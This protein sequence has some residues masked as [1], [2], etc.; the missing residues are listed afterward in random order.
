MPR[1]DSTRIRCAALVVLVTLGAAR[2]AGAEEPAVV[3]QPIA[4]AEPVERVQPAEAPP[5]GVFAPRRALIPV[6][7]DEAP[8]TR[9]WYGWQ[10][11]LADGA[12]LAAFAGCVSLM[13]PGDPELLCLIPFLGA[14]PAVH[15]AHD[16]PGR[17]LLSLALNTTLPFAGGAIGAAVADCSKDQFLCGLSEIGLG[18]LAGLATAVVIDTALAYE[19]VK[20]R[21]LARRSFMPTLAATPRGGAVGLVGQF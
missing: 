10:T 2:A 14:S 6:V 15:V 9:V 11:L 5:P 1:L 20:P 21:R 17:A 12:G 8:P 4:P 7:V 19:E 13:G 18:V 16:N 3:V